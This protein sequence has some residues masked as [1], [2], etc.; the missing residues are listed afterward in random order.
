MSDQRVRKRVGHVGLIMNG[1]RRWSRKHGYAIF[2]GYRR[3]RDVLKNIAR[4]CIEQSIPILTVYAFSTENRKRK[5]W[6]INFLMNLFHSMLRESIS[7]FLKQ[8]IRIRVIGD[9]EM[10]GK[11]LRSVIERAESQTKQCEKLLLQIAFYY[12]GRAEITYA[13]R[14]IARHV[15]H[16]DIDISD[17]TEAV[18]AQNL[19]THDVPDP[20]IIIRTGGEFRLSN[21]LLWQIAYSELFVVD[22]L[23]PDFTTEMFL[24]I[25]Q[26][27]HERKRT[28]GA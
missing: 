12:G 27:F 7:E 9:R 14:Q 6:E 21:F 24:S 25:I 13:V 17:I 3:G 26:M 16:G 2:N 15:A 11:K 22:T 20:D 8:G 23:W 5:Q 18:V 10:P 28:R 19:W 1:N 4:C